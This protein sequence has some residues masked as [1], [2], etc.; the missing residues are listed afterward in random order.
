M[1]EHSE[2]I[3]QPDGRVYHL[4]VKD[5]DIADRV[6]L[7]GDPA[8]VDMVA[9]HFDNDGAVEYTSTNREFRVKTGKYKGVRI[10]ALSTGIG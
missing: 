5:A 4:N 3:L 10:T 2:L 8:R 1:I 6:I 9:T 7:V